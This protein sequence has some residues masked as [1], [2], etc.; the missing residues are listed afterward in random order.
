MKHNYD[1]VFKKIVRE[2]HR[3]PLFVEK[4]PSLLLHV[5]CAPCSSSVLEQ[6]VHIFDITVYFYNPNIHP[7]EEYAKRLE[8]LKGFLPKFSKSPQINNENITF[9]AEHYEPN[10]FFEAVETEKYPELKAEA[11]KGERCSK[12]YEL[13]LQHTANYALEQNFDYFTTALSISPHKDAEKINRIGQKLYKIM[14][15][16]NVPL[17]VPQFVYADFKKR[18]GFKRSLEISKEFNLYRQEYCG[19]IYSQIA[20]RKKMVEKEML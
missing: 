16:N 6:L 12:C 2:V 20:T 9:K 14:Q 7:R 17:R 11:E 19:C 15:E 4:K 10:D 18:N 3:N 8:E 13:R 5:C 1:N